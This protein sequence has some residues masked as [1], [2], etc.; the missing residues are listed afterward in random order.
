MKLLFIVFFLIGSVFTSYAQF[1]SAEIGVD[2]LTCSACTK[3]VEMSLR[4]LDFVQDVQMN[5][6]NTNG[7]VTFKPGALI[8][9][10]KIA[11]A[12]DNAGFSVSYLHATFSFNS[13]TVFQ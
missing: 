7:K 1:V 6:E 10:D 2:G 12:V 9:I 8:Y 4:K 5:L 13:L 3:S 11:K